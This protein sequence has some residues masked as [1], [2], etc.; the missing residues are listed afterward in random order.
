MKEN[1]TENPLGGKFDLYLNAYGLYLCYGRIIDGRLFHL[2][3]HAGRAY[4][5]KCEHHLGF[6]C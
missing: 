6:F 3:M 1:V 4:C 2:S 5:V